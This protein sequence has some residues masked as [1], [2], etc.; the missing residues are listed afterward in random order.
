MRLVVGSTGL[1]GGIVTRRLLEQEEPVRILVRETSEYRP[2]REAGA[3]VVFG[4]LKEPV[5]LKEACVGADVVIALATS[6]NCVGEDDARSVDLEGNRSLIDAAADAGVRQFIFVSARCAAPDSPMPLMR[7]K[8]AAEQHLR[9]SGLTYTILQPDPFME[10]WITE[11]VGRP[12]LEH[13]PVVLVGEGD[14][15]HTFVSLSDVASYVV[16]V[17]DHE[18]ALDRTIQIGGPEVVSWRDVVALYARALGRSIEVKSVPAERAVEVMPERIAR[19]MQ[20]MECTASVIDMTQT[21]WIFDVT[22]TAL[23]VVIRR[24][25][26]PAPV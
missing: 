23:E 22:P 10:D 5:S 14:V 24:Q 8:A 6:M 13:R 7:A 4:D 17:I 26:E 18:E 19:M 25:V 20:A 1:L 11:V 2:L 15:R 16:A 21:A 9:E 3:E 12:A